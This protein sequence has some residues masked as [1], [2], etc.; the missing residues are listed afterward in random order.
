MIVM[1][2]ARRY[3]RASI[4]TRVKVGLAHAS[5]TSQWRLSACKIIFSDIF[6]LQNALDVTTLNPLRTRSSTSS[7]AHY[8]G[9]N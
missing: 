3:L 5:L 7:V 1:G 2:L 4:H 6:S 9:E 8:H